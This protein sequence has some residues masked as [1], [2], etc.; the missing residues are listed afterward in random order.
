MRITPAPKKTQLRA[1][2]YVSNLFF[3]SYMLYC[4]NT[5]R[6][7]YFFIEYI[8]KNGRKVSSTELFNILP[9]VYKRI[10]NIYEIRY[11]C[12]SFS[13]FS[14]I[15]ENLQELVGSCKEWFLTK[16][17]SA[18]KYTILFA[19]GVKLNSYGEFSCRHR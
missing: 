1:W 17:I 10:L 7:F 19:Q 16:Q 12:D 4:A 8:V 11:I 13:S 5:K 2:F 14:S 6:F 18:R 3:F 9:A 15:H